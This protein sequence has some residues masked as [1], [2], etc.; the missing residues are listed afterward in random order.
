MLANEGNT[1]IEPSRLVEAIKIVRN[2]SLE[3]RSRA[4]LAYDGG[5][6]VLSG[7]RFLKCDDWI[8][9]ARLLTTT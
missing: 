6:L 7:E 3:E 5:K 2:A 9:I 4:S 1:Q 8:N